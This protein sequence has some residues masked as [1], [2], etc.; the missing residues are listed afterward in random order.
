M[1]A[2]RSHRTT[3]PPT[4]LATVLCAAAGLSITTAAAP[5]I[6]QEPAAPAAPAASEPAPA[7][8]P[9]A[10]IAFTRLPPATARLQ[11]LD[12]LRKYNIPADRAAA[13]TQFWPDN[14][15][16]NQFSA[17][18]TFDRLIEAF[19]IADDS[20]TQLIK[21]CQAGQVPTAPDFTGPRSDPFCRSHLQLWLARWLV[22]HR[23]HDEALPLLES[24]NPEQ[25]ADPASL[26]FYRAA[27][28]LQL[29]QPGPAGND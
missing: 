26:F 23:C 3:F 15:S 2:Q 5:L 20:V 6:P 21:T 7:Q 27:S 25:L 4:A 1:P 17:E 24:L 11:L 14:P 19:A 12:W 28:R 16:I 13:A 8:P 9:D 22:Q 29:L 18:D 10:T